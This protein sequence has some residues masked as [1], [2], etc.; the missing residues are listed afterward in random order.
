MFAKRDR[1]FNLILGLLLVVGLSAMAYLNSIE[2]KEQAKTYHIKKIDA[3]FLMEEKKKEKPKPVV[4][5]KPKKKVVKKKPK[6]KKKEIK[7]ASKKVEITKKTKPK[8]KVRRV[9]GLKKVYSKGLGSGN[10]GGDAVVAKLG[11]TLDVPVDTVKATK[12]DLKGEVK[13]VT[14]VDKMPKILN[15]KKP[16][17]T[18][19]MKENQVEGKVKARVLVDIDGLV[20]K[21]V[22]LKDLGFGTKEESIKAIQRMKFEPGFLAGEPVAIWIPLTF[23][24]KLQG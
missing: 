9:Y 17:Y 19:E 18:P 8:K 11:N 10:G 12:A 4:K 7:K 2:V 3:S 6:P 20:K 1:A 16:E 24:F 13:S 15:Q 23:N 21:I 14:K 5:P 22:I